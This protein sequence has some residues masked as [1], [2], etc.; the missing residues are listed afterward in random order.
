MRPGAAPPAHGGTGGSL[1][2]ALPGAQSGWE[3]RR[4]LRLS[5]GWGSVIIPGAGGGQTSSLTDP[6]LVLYT[7]ATA[8]M[9][10]S[11]TTNVKP[12]HSSQGSLSPDIRHTGPALSGPWM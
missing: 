11:L 3:V 4:P 7:K 2:R 6:T 8:S 9:Q 5:S 12:T 1:E 10:P